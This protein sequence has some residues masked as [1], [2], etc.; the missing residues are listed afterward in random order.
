MNFAANRV[1]EVRQLSLIEP[2]ILQQTGFSRS[3]NCHWNLHQSDPSCHG[4]RNL[5]IL[6]QNWL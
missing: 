1:F 6:S 4:N 3:G 2:W 5:W